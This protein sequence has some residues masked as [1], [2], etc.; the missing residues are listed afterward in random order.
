[1]AWEQPRSPSLSTQGLYRDTHISR[2]A[3]QSITSF[4]EVWAAGLNWDAWVLPDRLIP[5]HFGRE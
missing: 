1:M 4:S 5:W 2:E 3:S